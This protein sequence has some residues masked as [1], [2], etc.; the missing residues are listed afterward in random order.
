MKVAAIVGARPQFVKAGPV[1]QAFAAAGHR[2][3]LIHTG[4]HYDANMS[5][6]FFSE[7]GLPEP[8]VNLEVGSGPQGWQTGLMLMRLEEVFQAEQPDWVLVYGDTNSTL[9]GSLAACKLR[10]PLAHVEAGLRSFNRAMPEEHNRVLADHCADLLLCPTPT[11]VANLEHEGVVQGVHLVGDPMYDAV[12]QF[13]ALAR[14]R[15]TLAGELQL[16]SG[17]YAFATIHRPYNTDDP[18]QLQRLLKALSALD[19]PVVFPVHPR[20][21][22]ALERWNVG[23]L[24]RSNVRLLEP[25]GYLDTLALLQDAAI[26]LTDSGGMQ[27]EAFW[28]GVPCVTLRPE[29]EW[30]ETVAAGWNRLAWTDEAAI[31]AAVRKPWPTEPPPQVFGQPGASTRIVKLMEEAAGGR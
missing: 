4:Q 25:L 5:Q 10:L 8:A 11:A 29:T 9:A 18:V 21:R 14:Q 24:E 7:L 15:S 17:G 20:T 13:A 28:L 1:S 23:T 19:L 22:G 26:L 6:V 30:V 12:L 16:T 27:K 2:E 3:I 31:L